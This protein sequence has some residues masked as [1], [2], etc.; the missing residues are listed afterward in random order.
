MNNLRAFARFCER[1]NQLAHRS[2][3]LAAGIFR[4]SFRNRSVQ[5]A[6]VLTSLLA[7]NSSIA[8]AQNEV[9]CGAAVSQ[10]QAYV[11]QVNT[12]AQ[13]E[14]SQGIRARC[15]YNGYC[16]QALLQQLSAWYAQQSMLVNQWYTTIARQCSTRP[17]ARKR[18]SDPSE[19]IEDAADIK[20][21]NEDKTVR[22]KI[23]SKPSGYSQRT[24]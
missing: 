2:A 9:A 8:L 1:I 15:G 19:Q 23:P 24:R 11:Q 12:I 10:L 14:Y 20:V 13:V 3:G 17:T 6:L 16:A 18:Q 22:I 5:T 7:M 21:D 4:S